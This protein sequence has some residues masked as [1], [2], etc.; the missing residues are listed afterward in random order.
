MSFVHASCVYGIQKELWDELSIL[1][2]GCAAWAIVGDFNIVTSSTERKGGSIPC[3]AAVIEFN[4]FIH[5]NALVDS[6]T[7]GFKY[8]WCNKRRG[9]QRM[10]Q[11]IDIILINQQW[12]DS[13]ASWKSR[14]MKRKLSDHSP[15]VGWNTKIP[16]PTNIPFKFKRAWILHANL[17][18]VIEKSWP[19]PLFDVPIRKVTKKLKRLKMVLKDWNYKIYGFSSISSLVIYVLHV[20]EKHGYIGEFEYVNDH[21]SGKIV[22][23]LNGRLNKCGVISPRFDVGV[24]D[25]EPWTARLLPSR[26][27]PKLFL[28]D[29]A[30]WIYYDNLS[31]A[32]WIMKRR[33]R[34]NVGGKVP[35]FF[36]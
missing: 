2:S 27:H 23:E 25:I 16:K 9:A 12:I 32:S 15:I 30:V 29:T 36:Y 33:G 17:K 18:E 34:K 26:Q 1:E 5:S 3:L 7:M 4:S 21:R 24:K 28:L 13:S 20:V 22:V 31:L 8:S 14:I 6:T 19:E 35:R 10:Y 11:K